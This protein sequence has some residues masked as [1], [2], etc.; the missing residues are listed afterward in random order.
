MKRIIFTGDF[1]YNTEQHNKKY[2]F[3]FFKIL[4][5]IIASALGDNVKILFEIVNENGEKFSREHFYKLGGITKI[6]ESY[7][8]YNISTFKKRGI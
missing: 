4:K 8:Q 7:N 5:P 6:K 2:F 1:L 3:W